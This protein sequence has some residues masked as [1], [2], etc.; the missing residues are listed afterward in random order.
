MSCLWQEDRGSSAV[1][2]SAARPGTTGAA[3]HAEPWGRG[4]RGKRRR[5]SAA[6]A[7]YGERGP[8]PKSRRAE[9][10]F[11]ELQRGGTVSA[12]FPSRRRFGRRGS[13]SGVAASADSADESSPRS[14]LLARSTCRPGQASLLLPVLLPFFV[15]CFLRFIVI[16]Q[17]SHT[18]RRECRRSRGYR[19]FPMMGRVEWS[20]LQG[21]GSSI[22]A[23]PD[24]SGEL[25][26]SGEA[27]RSLVQF[28]PVRSQ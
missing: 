5:D 11:S 1:A 17:A 27:S 16:D 25:Q 8:G 28:H 24:E 26:S 4:R 3:I 14:A 7:P 9:E 21:P 10:S 20:F 18:E 19:V 22:S 6:V 2:A 12:W 15:A 13:R 23:A